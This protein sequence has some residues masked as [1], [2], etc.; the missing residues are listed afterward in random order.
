MRVQRIGKEIGFGFTRP[1]LRRNVFRV[2]GRLFW[3]CAN[4]T[5]RSVC[6]PFTRFR[7][8]SSFSCPLSSY[9][10]IFLAFLSCYPLRSGSPIQ[11]SMPEKVSLHRLIDVTKRYEFDVRRDNNFPFYPRADRR[12]REIIR[13][14]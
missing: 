4:R 10:L 12:A 14:E 6:R 9:L 3:R 8:S 11:L 2:Y 7:Y 5:R 1:H 13:K